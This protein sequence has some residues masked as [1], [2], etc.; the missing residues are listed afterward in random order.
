ML[1]TCLIDNLIIGRIDPHIYAFSTNTI[2]NYLKVG[3]TYRPVEVRLDEWRDIFPNLKHS[4][5]WEWVAKTKDGKYFRDFAVHYYLEQIKHLHRLQRDEFP[6][7]PYSKEFFEHAKPR[8]ID[9]AIMDIEARA[10]QIG[11][12]Y[13]YYSEE[14][15]PI[16]SHYARTENYPL[17]PNQEAAVKAFNRARD[18]GRRHLLMYAVMRFGKSFTSMW[19]ATEMNAKMVLILSAKADVREEWKKTVESHTHFEDYVFMDSASLM[20]S[21]TVLSDTLKQGKRVALFLTL[22]DLMGEDIKTKHKELFRTPINLLIVDET[23]FGARADEYGR[24]LRDSQLDTRDIK[25]EDKQ[26]QKQI[27]N[28]FE[29]LE[30]GLEQVKR[31]QINTTLHLSGTPYRILMGSEFKRD[32]IIAFCQFT[33]I[34]DAKEQWDKEHTGDIDNEVLNP[35]TH[36]PYQ[37]WDNPYYGFPQMIRFAFNPN[38]SAMRLIERLHDEGKTASLNELFRPQS[39]TKAANNGHK[40]FIH[41]PE[42]LDLLRII[43]GSEKDDNI[44]GFLDYAKLKEG[45]MCR[46]MVF[47]LPFCASCDAMQALLAKQARQ[48]KNLKDYTI[49]NIAGVENTFPSTEAVKEHIHSLEQQGK[50]SITLTVNR[51]LTGSTVCE[52]DTMLFLKDVSSP[53][54]YDQAIFRLQNQYVTTYASEKE[55]TIKYNMKPQT[56]LVD[57]DP[58]RMFVMQEQKSKIYNVNTNERGNEELVQRI[59]RE[60]QVSPIIVV[61]KNKLVE[62]TPTNIMDAVR[63]YSANKTVMDEANNIP[64]DY[65]IVNDPTLWDNLKDIK[66]I[67]TTKGISV[68]PVE[69]DGED[70]D[71]PIDGEPEESTPQTDNRTTEAPTNTENDE[72]RDKRLSTLFAMILFFALLTEDEVHSLRECI[73]A[74]HDSV[75][76]RRIARNVGLKYETLIHLRQHLNP[77]V[78][79]ELDYKIQNTNQLLNDTTH[80]P[81]ERLE[82]ALQKFGRLSDAEVV[83]PSEVADKMVALLP[84]LGANDKVLDIASK[85][86]E[87]ACALYRRYGNKILNNVYSLP[88]SS[89]A[90]EF[91]YKVYR[92]LDM[93]TQHIISTFTSFDLIKENIDLQ[94]NTL[95]NMK[96]SAIVGNPPYQMSKATENTVS[97]AAFASALYPLFIEQ[98]L[99]L[100][101]PS[102]SMIT[103]SR[104]MT[105]AGQGVSD[106]WVD[107]MIQGN[108]FVEIHDYLS[109][110]E[111]FA[112]VEIKGGVSYFLYKPSH[113]GKCKYFLHNGIN[114]SE[115]NDYLDTLGAGVVIRDSMAIEIIRRLMAVEGQYFNNSSFYSMVSPKHYFDKDDILGSN[116]R[117]YSKNR[118]ANHPIKLYLN[119]RL[120]SCGYGWIKETD[121]P[122][123]HSTVPLYKIFIP[124]AGGSGTDSIILGQ[125]I[126]GEPNSVCSYTYLCIGYDAVRHNFSEQECKNIISYINTRFFRYLV[127]VKKKT[128]DAARDVYQFVPLQNF[129]VHS[130]IDWSKS[131]ADIDK[132]L[133][134][135]YNLSA[136][137]IKFI[138][139]MIKPME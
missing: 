28:T 81:Q 77:F 41:E 65:D 18:K 136:D 117:G 10:S 131:V 92:L 86:G 122:R 134:A 76:N 107:K 101:A 137:E 73:E 112:G 108:H 128:Q 26:Q 35:Q 48:F 15:L 47:V 130:D 51:M 83:T 133:Y 57:F 46:H 44:L 32:D 88:T 45:K 53:Q 25:K 49:V 17:R 72:Q 125:P 123:S 82:I 6:D 56:L 111:C 103:P 71:I 132:Q 14:R 99:K 38:K 61:N 78:L 29:D 121:I 93:P 80:K 19:C 59:Q 98:V 126:L 52:W 8:D 109:A 4:S 139:S 39:I 43:D 89:L 104:W 116:W 84:E 113:S 9:E 22:Q 11:S 102:V 33:D 58:S 69:G 27:D 96:F 42:V 23:H 36:R 91:T 50:K 138:E 30:Q 67:D 135:K 70:Y 31:L 1:D 95:V 114:I 115:R 2:P 105:K 129:T 110:S 60:L 68:K 13:Q 24:V 85:Q 3:D 74:I 64:V 5:D 16:E 21:Q 87:F 118:D 79:S 54:E 7:L 20:A 40:K 100:N 66:P 119:K 12:P 120:E 127:S 90:Y 63:A 106:E 94:I 37:E 75:D 97:N 62:A 34:I 124:K 55:G